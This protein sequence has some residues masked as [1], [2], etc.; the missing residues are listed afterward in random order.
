MK[1]RLLGELNG[2]LNRVLHIS[3][4]PSGD[5]LVSAA[6]DET[7]RFWKLYNREKNKKSNNKFLNNTV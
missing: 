3:L 4:N 6:A 2:H 5:T 1:F 7:L